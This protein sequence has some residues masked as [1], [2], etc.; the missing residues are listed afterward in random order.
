MQ[1]FINPGLKGW[2]P[3]SLSTIL[4]PSCRSRKLGSSLTAHAAVQ[5]PLMVRAARG[6]KTERAPCWMMRQAGRS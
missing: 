5:D 3:I 6:E 4:T 1:S 2:K